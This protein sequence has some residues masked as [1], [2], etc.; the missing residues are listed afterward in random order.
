M[1]INGY[2][3]LDLSRRGLCR[4]EDGSRGT[5]WNTCLINDALVNALIELLEVIREYF[6]K[7]ALT[8]GNMNIDDYYSIWPLEKDSSVL[9]RQFPNSAAIRI[10]QNNTAIF[11]SEFYRGDWLSYVDCHYF[12]TSAFSIREDLLSF[13]GAFSAKRGI[14]FVTLPKKFHEREVF[15]TIFT[16]DSDKLFDMQRI[17]REL[18]FPFLQKIPLKYVELILQTVLHY[19][20]EKWASELLSQTK[21]IP[22]GIGQNVTFQFPKQVISPESRFAPLYKP[23]EMRTPHPFVAH[24]FKKESDFYQALKSLHVIHGKLP[25]EDVVDRLKNQ[26]NLDDKER[27]SHCM[28]LIE[29]LNVKEVSRMAWIYDE[30]KKVDFIP[31]WEDKLFSEMR[32]Q[33]YKKYTCPTK[34]FSYISRY[35]I[36]P[37]FYS[38]NEKIMDMKKFHD[39]FKIPSDVS[40][41]ILINLLH[42]FHENET[43]IK[44]RKLTKEIT[45]RVLKIYYSLETLSNQRDSVKQ[46]LLGKNWIWHPDFNTFYEISE[47]T[48]SSQYEGFKSSFL[49]CFPFTRCE[50]SISLDF[51]YSLGLKKEIEIDCVMNVVNSM[52]KIYKNGA[53][54]PGD[55]GLILRLILDFYNDDSGLRLKY[56]LSASNTLCSV[57]ELIRDDMPWKKKLFSENCKLAHPHIPLICLHN[58]K[59]PSSRSRLYRN[60]P[61]QIHRF[62]QYEDISTRIDNF[63]RDCPNESTILKEF[64]QNAE[65]ASA[66][67]FCIILD[68]QTY[69]SESLCFPNE[70]M[71]KL[72]EY[73]T[74]P[75]LLIYNNRAFTEE[76]LAGIQSVGLGGKRSKNTIGKFGLGFNAVYH[77]TESPCLLTRRKLS[78]GEFVYSYCIFDPYRKYLNIPRTEPPGIRLDLTEENFSEF[79]DQ[80]KPF[81]LSAITSQEHICK[82]NFSDLKGEFTI[83]RIPFLSN[84]LIP[85]KVKKMTSEFL[86]QGSEIN[87]FLEAVKNISLF[88]IDLGTAKRC[89]TLTCK[90]M[91]HIPNEPS[92]LPLTNLGKIHITLKRI[93]TEVEKTIIYSNQFSAL[94]QL[95]QPFIV[96]NSSWLIYNFKGDLQG[97]ESV[98]P[99]LKKY[100]SR[101]ENEKL[102]H[103]IYGGVAIK[104]PD[105]IIEA[106]KFLR[107][108][109]LYS[110]LPLGNFVSYHD[111]PVHINAPFIVDPHRQFLMFQEK[112]STED[113]Q[114]HDVW[115]IGILN[116][117]IVPLYATLLIDLKSGRS[118]H[119]KDLFS[120][121]NVPLYF[122]WYYSLFPNMELLE[123]GQ[124]QNSSF[125]FLLSK[126]LISW[127]YRSHPQM[128]VDE[129]YSQWYSFSG[130]NRG[131]FENMEESDVSIPLNLV[132][133]K[134]KYPLTVAPEHIALCLSKFGYEIQKVEQLHFL[135]YLNRN[136]SFLMKDQN[137]S[138]L[139]FDEIVCLLEFLFAADSGTIKGYG[140]IPLKLDL[141]R[142]L[143][144]FSKS[145]C[146]TFN[147]EYAK[148]LPHFKSRF[149]DKA[150]PVTIISQLTQAGYIEDL[151]I[152]FLIHNI[153][154]ELLDLEGV[155]L[156]WRYVS[157]IL[158]RNVSL[159]QKFGKHKLVP[160]K[161]I[162]SQSVECLRIAQ[163]PSIL[164]LK[165]EE[166]FDIK[167]QL[168]SNTLGKLG[169]PV[170]ALES[171]VSEELGV[172]LD[173]LRRCLDQ[174][175]I[176]KSLQYGDVVNALSLATTGSLEN[177]LSDQEANCLRG[178]VLQKK[179]SYDN[180]ELT[181][182]SLLKIFLTNTNKLVSVKECQ[183][184][185]I[186]FNLFPIGTISKIDFSD[187]YIISANSEEDERKLRELL[188]FRSVSLLSLQNLFLECIFPQFRNLPIPEQQTLL[189]CIENNIEELE[190]SIIEEL[191]SIPFITVGNDQ[192][193][194]DELYNPDVEL[195][196]AFYSD[197]LI[198]QTWIN[199]CSKILYQLGLHYEED[200]DTIKECAIQVSSR[201]NGKESDKTN[202]LPLIAFIKLLKSEI[203]PASLI[204]QFASIAFISQW[205]YSSDFK[206]EHR[207]GCLPDANLHVNSACCSTVT[208][209]H[210]KEIVGSDFEKF[211]TLK[212][213]QTP[214]PCDVVEHLKILSTNFVLAHTRLK[215]IVNKLFNS[216]YSHLSS[217]DLPWSIPPNTQ[218][219]LHDEKLYM[220]RNMVFETQDEI[221]PYFFKVP[222]TLAD[223][224]NF[225]RKIAVQDDPNHDHYTAVMGDL[226][227]DTSL[228]QL[229]IKNIGKKTFLLFINILRELESSN[230]TI[231]LNLTNILVFTQNFNIIPRSDVIYIDNTKLMIHL[232]QF[233]V[234]S[235]LELLHELPPNILGSCEPPKCLQITGLS[236]LIQE[237]LADKTRN[238][239][240]TSDSSK[241]I[242]NILR[243]D[244]FMNGLIRI[245]YHETK[246]NGKDN[247]KFIKIKDNT[248]SYD[249][250]QTLDPSFKS[251]SQILNE[252]KVVAVNSIDIEVTCLKDG[253]GLTRKDIYQCFK[254]HS[255]IYACET[256][257]SMAIF[258]DL[259]TIINSCLGDIFSQ[260]LFYLHSCLTSDKIT[261]TLNS[262]NISQ[263]PH[264][265]NS[266]SAA[267][268]PHSSTGMTRAKLFKRFHARK[269]VVH[270]PTPSHA[271]T[272]IPATIPTHSSPAIYSSALPSSSHSV[273]PSSSIEA[274]AITSHDTHTAQLWIRTAQCDLRAAQKLIHKCENDPSVYASHACFH[275]FDCAIKA[276]IAIICL[277]RFYQVN[278]S[279]E[280]NLDIIIEIVKQF[281]SGDEERSKLADLCIP[282]MNYNEVARDPCMTPGIGCCIPIQCYPLEAAE[283]AIT[284]ASNILKLIQCSF[285]RIGEL[286]FKDED[287]V[288]E[289]PPI[290]SLLKTQLENCKS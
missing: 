243:A 239:Y 105:D 91:Q 202:L 224:H 180:Q 41:N 196:Q 64:L 261:E 205:K 203:A 128:L 247:L 198:P 83:F 252:L 102:D 219:I 89:G 86:H 225:L 269:S 81:S 115:H 38:I 170:L 78:S 80:F 32:V 109:F 284:N 77:L 26:V 101:Y 276:C 117:V 191:R 138:I 260:N 167:L 13:V 253:T 88:E 145:S 42:L 165:Q 149:Y 103:S 143:S 11:F 111:Y 179:D 211:G 90:S 47:I 268:A 129:T 164:N 119:L 121:W 218:C 96:K 23:N 50:H 52:K 49:P 98:Y 270:I 278:I 285:P 192:Y 204:D 266:T 151:P 44:E 246:S 94:T 56:V 150:Y 242:Q 136:I 95:Y 263:C 159:I 163:L 69:P 178:L 241:F 5:Q 152:Q 54:S 17:L 75:S 7:Q 30:V 15:R 31:V 37:E 154:S 147:S 288:W 172:N 248:V 229:D 223:F 254:E 82:N 232:G 258:R 222:H 200:V 70:D 148:L 67:E 22:C 221:K 92:M 72:P 279:A 79:P 132:L 35:L 126:Q 283:E 194:V 236:S 40:E 161:R 24:L 85:E 206:K 116:H 60:V 29:S 290:K 259:T 230:Q 36:T 137:N 48:E 249:S 272:S 104:I 34:C 187:I 66:S 282:L 188:S 195:F 2:F 210:C 201:N 207:L 43:I 59:V 277:H 190:S 144:S 68:H 87:L 169:C 281:F 158:S 244:E 3:E 173:M 4:T 6:P 155:I 216:S 134:L 228:S 275:C 135:N 213:R 33:K 123:K 251:V 280:R 112:D 27:L 122:E 127:L 217:T 199:S 21:C 113:Q 107:K 226:L 12:I 160:V 274:T 273:V 256:D 197:F 118:K 65:D 19:Y 157:T 1:S 237:S 8:S 76:D 57:G 166:I 62:G 162:D 14:Y 264:L 240:F 53:L 271:P 97:L 18:L 99:D 100:K 184:C 16:N 186:N 139:S 257:D 156:F 71:P 233:P 177:V 185:F 255:I 110:Y 235:N 234:L 209:I 28:I 193:R 267:T 171:L 141:S 114:W 63:K 55:A 212:V 146:T 227:A 265:D 9:W 108:A 142:N 182:F 214:D 106:S 176:Y 73:Q 189:K 130:E 45:S 58:L 238:G 208:W 84:I 183:K 175:T 93:E 168:L 10:I 124:T 245:Y 20:K 215:N 46:L 61:F 131:V 125:L 133:T 287:K 120:N 51:F 25:P 262:F 153:K 74:C 286:M 39:N 174:H 231:Q 220:A 289:C 250:D 181:I 140:D